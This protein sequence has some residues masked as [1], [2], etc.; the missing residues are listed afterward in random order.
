MKLDVLVF[1]AHPDDAELSCGGTIA[2]L[3]SQ[4]KSVGIVDFT[5][6]EM[7]TRGTPEIRMQEA[8]ESAQILGLSARHNLG[9]KDVFFAL[10]DEHVIKVVEQIRRFQPEVIL[11][12]AIHD[13]HP[14]HGK[15][16][17]L[18]KKSLFFAGLEKLETTYEGHKQEI[19]RAQNLYHY[20]QTDWMMPDFVVD[21]SA[22]WDTKM[23]AIKAFKTQFFDPDGQS[24]N[25][26][27]SSSN[28]MEF[29]DARG[30][31]L[32][33]SIRSTYGEGFVKD[34]MLGVSDITLLL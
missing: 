33:M 7:G 6:G 27:I 12:N 23:K 28:F 11:A 14:D 25:T 8:A 13:R 20:V 10:D 21:V 34:R 22:H 15:G 9:F 31:E 2:S 26:L 5:R 32:G 4:G 17:E 19:W 3:V 29:L 30:R 24:A 1:A 16:A 18:V